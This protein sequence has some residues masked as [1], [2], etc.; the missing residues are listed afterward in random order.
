MLQYRHHQEF[1]KEEEEERVGFFLVHVMERSHDVDGS[2]S[3]VNQTGARLK[4]DDGLL[5]S[6]S[7]KKKGERERHKTM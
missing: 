6:Q 7:K 2:F 4:F 3:D 5:K 1:F